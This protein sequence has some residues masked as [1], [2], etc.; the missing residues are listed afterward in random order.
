M[1]KLA[2][3]FIAE[4]FIFTRNFFDSQNPR[5]IFKSGFK[6]RAGYNGARMVYVCVYQLMGV[7]CDRLNFCCTAAHDCRSAQKKTD[8]A[9]KD[10][11][12]LLVLLLETTNL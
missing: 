10:L 11:L 3:V 4:G 8:I 9:K 12:L 6:S 7:L 2:E 5:F 1:V